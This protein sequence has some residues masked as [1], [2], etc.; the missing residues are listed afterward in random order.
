MS[1]FDKDFIKCVQY[2]F[3]I[4]VQILSNISWYLKY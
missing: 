3:C 4:E 2:D 1:K